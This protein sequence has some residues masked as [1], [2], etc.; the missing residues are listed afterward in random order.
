MKT[1]L[2]NQ[3]K[4]SVLNTIVRIVLIA[5]LAGLVITFVIACKGEQYPEKLKGTVNVIGVMKV[6]ETVE[7]EITE[8]NG[9]ANGW[10]YQW[11]RIDGEGI[12]FNIE[13]ETGK[14][15]VITDKDVGF[16]LNVLV[17][18]S[19]TTG[20]IEGTSASA[21]VAERSENI[22]IAAGKTVTV[23]FTATT[24]NDKPEWWDDLEGALQALASVFVPGNY[25]LN[26][27]SDGTDGFAASGSKTATVSDDWLSKSDTVAMYLAVNDILADWI[28]AMSNSRG[29][30][31][32]SVGANQQHLKPM[33]NHIESN[34]LYYSIYYT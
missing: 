18:N 2:L 31:M 6:D 5:I 3:M 16:K 27:T 9:S 25:I 24:K 26:V 11:R 21:V 32:A 33:T 15:Y 30:Y 14:T 12:I 20:N 28:I 1:G 19:A 8:H 29:V 34:I 4:K 10:T 13:G 22:T 23:N 17:S 7:I